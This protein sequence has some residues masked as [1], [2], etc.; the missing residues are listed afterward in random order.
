MGFAEQLKEI[1]SRLP[2]GRQTLLFSATLPKLLVEF[3]QAGEK[4]V[5][6]WV[7]SQRVVGELDVTQGI[8]I[9]FFLT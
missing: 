2:D 1:V 9:E 8:C 3:A 5:P 6:D 4:M 7:C